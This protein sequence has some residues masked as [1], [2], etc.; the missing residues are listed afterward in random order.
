M[1]V[2]T[3]VLKFVTFSNDAL[4]GPVPAWSSLQQ[5]HKAVLA[6]QGHLL[7]LCDAFMMV[8]QA[9]E[10]REGLPVMEGLP[11]MSPAGR[12]LVLAVGEQVGAVHVGLCLCPSQERGVGGLGRA[13]CPERGKHTSRVMVCLPSRLF[14]GAA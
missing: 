6:V 1:Q 4:N 9:D 5:R 10:A 12:R 13:C 11:A 2:K 8:T 14:E 3:A 7:H